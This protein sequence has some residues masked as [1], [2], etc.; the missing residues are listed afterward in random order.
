MARK[1]PVERLIVRPALNGRARNYDWD[2]WLDGDCWECVYGEDFEDI[3]ATKFISAAR[4]AAA[5]RGLL[6]ETHMDS[7][8]VCIIR[9][10]RP[11][12]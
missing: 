8:T 6:L 12:E 2:N 4:K 11:G 10:Y 9:A 7:P 3:S 1:V 5:A